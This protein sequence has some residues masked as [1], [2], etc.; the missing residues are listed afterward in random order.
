MLAGGEGA[1]IIYSAAAGRQSAP[2]AGGVSPHICCLWVM[3]TTTCVFS[4]SGVSLPLSD[5]G[6][7]PIVVFGLRAGLPSLVTSR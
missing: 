6:M 5:Q 1:Q 3:S 2:H 4:V 7:R